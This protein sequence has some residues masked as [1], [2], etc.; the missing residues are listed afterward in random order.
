MI[1]ISGLSCTHFR[2]D[3]RDVLKGINFSLKERKVVIV[4]PNGSGK[5]SLLR[6]CLGLMNITD[7]YVKVNGR[8]VRKV[9]N[10]DGVATNL[11]E[12]YKLLNLKIWDLINLYSEITGSEVG[13]FLKNI[14]DFSIDDILQKKI[15]SLS[16]GQSKLLCNIMAL[17]SNP[18][19][20][21]LDEP[22]EGVDRR[23]K[24]ILLERLNSFSGEIV[25]NTHELDMVSGLSGWDLYLLIDG[26]LYG[27]FDAQNINHL[28]FNRGNR[29]NAL[30]AITLPY[31]TFSITSGK[32]DIPLSQIH[33]LENLMEDEFP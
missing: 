8:D 20:L 19:I 13:N 1:E 10:M 28:F 5:T 31:G 11:S 7:G 21:L 30:T 33:T 15:Y 17:S 3:K 26:H 32:G 25:M 12:V 22:F 14:N 9:R 2:G 16:T 18:N 23:R 4:G 24:R 27:P 29:E 6:A